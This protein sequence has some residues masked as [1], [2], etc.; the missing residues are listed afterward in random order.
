MFTDRCEIPV[1]GSTCVITP[2]KMPDEEIKERNTTKLSQAGGGK[3][4]VKKPPSHIARFM[5]PDAMTEG[6]PTEKERKKKVYKPG[7]RLLK[8]LHKERVAKMKEASRN[9]FMG[10]DDGDADILIV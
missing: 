8:R 10:A 9:A 2:H 7:E 4:P 1:F 3:I 5:D 6:D